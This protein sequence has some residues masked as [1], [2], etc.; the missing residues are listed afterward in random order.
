MKECPMSK[1]RRSHILTIGKARLKFG[2]V[3]KPVWSLDPSNPFSWRDAVSKKSSH[4]AA[5]LHEL[6]V[7][8]VGTQTSPNPPPLRVHGTKTDSVPQLEL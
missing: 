3:T 4:Y 8:C 7:C 5:P 6:G 2:P 1:L